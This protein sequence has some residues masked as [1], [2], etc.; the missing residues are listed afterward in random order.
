MMQGC[1]S[2]QGFTSPEANQP[3]V[4]GPPISDIVTPLDNALSCLDGKIKK[5]YTFAVG[6]VVD[7]TGKEQFT[8][9]GSGKFITQGAGDIVQSALYRAGLNMVN[10]RDPRIMEQETKWGLQK[11]NTIVGSDFFVTGSI[12]SLDFIPGG[13]VDVSVGGVGPSYSQNRILVSLDLS[14]TDTKTGVIVSNVSL[15]KQIFA[16]DINFGVGRFIG[17]QLTSIQIGVK[18]R[19][20][21]HYSLR[22]MLNLASYDLLT[23][24]MEVRKYKNCNTYIANIKETVDESELTRLETGSARRY[25]TIAQQKSR[26]TPE[27]ILWK[28]EMP[29]LVNDIDPANVIDEQKRQQIIL[30]K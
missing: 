12:N 25:Q 30:S 28:E 10:R 22:Q 4:R 3:L 5:D 8:D 29:G 20:A 27:D 7:L 18:E 23:Q 15:Q 6:A 21:L 16:D 26:N 1:A 24:L 11:V 19:E 2:I 13:G 17:K 14:M 9:G